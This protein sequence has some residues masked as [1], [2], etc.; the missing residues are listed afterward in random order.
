MIRCCGLPPPVL[1]QLRSGGTRQL[2]LALLGRCTCEF[3]S[4]RYL[5]WA[6]DLDRDG[7]PDHLI[8]FGEIGGPV[9][10]Y[11]SGDAKAGEQVRL[12]G[13]YNGPES[14]HHCLEQRR[15]GVA[16]DDAR[17]FRTRPRMIGMSRRPAASGGRARQSPP[18]GRPTLQRADCAPAQRAGV[19]PKARRNTAMKLLVSL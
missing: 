18:G 9:H 4:E 14:H 5:L 11:L 6:G 13:V 16:L 15:R 2:L 8:A 1:L 17:N 19:V 7:R 10:L 3:S 12:A